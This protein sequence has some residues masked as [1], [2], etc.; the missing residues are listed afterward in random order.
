MADALPA[1][2]ILTM[3]PARIGDFFLLLQQGFTVPVLVGGT[4]ESLLELQWQL[5]HDYVTERISTIFLDN[6]PIDDLT[7]AIIRE[8]SVIALSGA[9][10]GLVGATMRRDGFYSKLRQNITHREIIA[11]ATHRVALI[12][13]KIFNMLLPELGPDFLRRG[14]ILGINELVNFLKDKTA[15]FRQDCMTA[16]FGGEV[17]APAQLCAEILKN[18]SKTVNLHVMTREVCS[19]S[20]LKLKIFR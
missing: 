16:E 19:I 7:T 12:R 9:M 8:N 11:G 1:E 15:V 17:V 20:I 2:L 18:G 4:L 6:H 10:P 13:V 5:A 14:I 3:E